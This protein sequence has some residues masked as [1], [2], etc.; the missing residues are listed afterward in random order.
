MGIEGTPGIL[1]SA[2]DLLPG[3]LPPD[4]LIKELQGPG[5]G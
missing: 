2:G 5:S 3:Y 1:T 4:V